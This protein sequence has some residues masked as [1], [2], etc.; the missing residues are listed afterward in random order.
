MSALIVA[1]V[2][3]GDD[4]TV[5][6]ASR[7][8][9]P[10]LRGRFEFPGGKVEAGE[11]AGAALRRELVEELGVDARLGPVLPNPER[12][13]RLWP[14]VGAATLLAYW[15]RL[16]PGSQPRLTAAH[17]RHV[18]QPRR[19]LE[20]LDWLDPDIPIARLIARTPPPPIPNDSDK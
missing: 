10:H 16:R 5:F 20:D 2:I 6:A 7:A 1:A 3:V 9:P 17:V 11:D 13:D 8:Y 4:D 12:A 19:H 14:L 18:W 15:A